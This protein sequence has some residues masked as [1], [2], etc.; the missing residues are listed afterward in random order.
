MATPVHGS[1]YAERPVPRAHPGAPGG[2][3]AP[4]RARKKGTRVTL[5]AL[6]VCAAAAYPVYQFV[7]PHDAEAQSATCWGEFAEIMVTAPRPPVV[8]CGLISARW[9]VTA[10]VKPSD[11]PTPCKDLPKSKG[12]E[13]GMEWRA[14]DG[15]V[16]C[17]TMT[18]HTSWRDYEKIGTMPYAFN[19]ADFD[20]IKLRLLA[21]TGQQP[22]ASPT[23][24]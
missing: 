11:N 9:R 20:E 18:P 4:R 17:L 10:V 22:T 5:W 15:T 16:T 12:Y 13:P 2:H 1:P 7:I 24:G 23:P 14:K 3:S 8:D 6:A 21:A 19:H